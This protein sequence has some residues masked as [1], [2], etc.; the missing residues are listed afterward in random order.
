MDHEHLAALIAEMVAGHDI[1]AVQRG[2]V[3]ELPAL[4]L[5]V[6]AGQVRNLQPDVVELRVGVRL[7]EL[8]GPA[9]DASVGMA[10]GATSAEVNAVTHWMHSVLP[11]FVAVRVPDHPMARDVTHLEGHDSAGARTQLLHTPTMIR[12]WGD[13]PTEDMVGDP[14]PAVAVVRQLLTM[15][16]AATHP[17]WVSAVCGRARNEVR[18]NNFVVTEDFPDCDSKV[19]WGMRDG[20]LKQWAVFR[21]MPD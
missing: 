7:P 10:E 4:D 17:V 21:V 19:D 1:E 13:P 3:V 14:P 9:W 12:T 11:L 8:G 6:M 20:T 2:E 18:V 15:S 16:R 5:R